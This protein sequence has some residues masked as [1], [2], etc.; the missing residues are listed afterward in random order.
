LKQADKVLQPFKPSFR[1][2]HAAGIKPAWTGRSTSRNS[3]GSI[4]GNGFLADSF[5]GNI[6]LTPH[7]AAIVGCAKPGV[8]EN[9]IHLKTQR[10]VE[11][12][13]ER[14]VRKMGAARWRWGGDK[15][16]GNL[17]VLGQ[18]QTWAF[19]LLWTPSLWGITI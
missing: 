4:K 5:S 19:Q 6:I 15:R 13:L 8:E 2:C 1:L 7:L 3:F 10:K 12:P 18:I 17:P 11:K 9:S 14:Y 16:T